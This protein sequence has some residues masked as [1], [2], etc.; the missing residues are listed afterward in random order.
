M[1]ATA[2]SAVFSL[3]RKPAVA[4]LLLA[5]LVVGT[6]G[7]ASAASGGRMG[8]SS[9]SKSGRSGGGGGGGGGGY[10]RSY[11]APRSSGYSGPSFSA[12][13]YGP[14]LSPYSPL[15][16]FGG[17]FGSYPSR[18]VYKSPGVSVGAGS[19]FLNVL[20][21]GMAGVFVW[22]LIST[23]LTDRAEGGLLGATT[24][25]SVVRVQVGLLGLARTFQK[26]LDRI[27]DRADTGTPEGLHFM[28]TETVLALLRHPDMV[29]YG[30]STQSDV[31]K[32]AEEGERAFNAASL[33]ERSKFD[34]ETLSN[35]GN[36]RRRVSR[37]LKAERF[38]NEYIVV[39]VLVAA[40]G[41]V[42][43]PAINSMADLRAAL[44]KLGSLTS[45]QV[46]AVEILWTP[47]D[48]DDTLT[49]QEVL[50]DYPRLRSI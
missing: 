28:L 8:G 20:F 9:F 13:Y 4:A 42:Q 40:E 1:L 49:E 23:F 39:T 12:P 17:G 43:L 25:T 22:N 46:Q 2:V 32:S 10:S 50:R 37:A 19:G 5:L 27:A 31:K 38:N 47:Q 15:G 35:V 45:D 30:H 16:G 3:L 7:L 48:E 44:S 14:S 18:G 41:K 21:F 33:E 24:T 26:D 34:Q 36:V 6:P 29:V 11:S